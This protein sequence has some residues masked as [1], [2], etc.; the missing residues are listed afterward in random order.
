MMARTDQQCI[1][2]AH[3]QDCDLRMIDAAPRHHDG[4]SDRREQLVAGMEVSSHKA[5]IVLL[6]EFA[7]LPANAPVAI[8]ATSFTRS[9]KSCRRPMP[10]KRTA[11]GAAQASTDIINISVM[12]GVRITVVSEPPSAYW[13]K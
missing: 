6:E 8:A 13:W 2:L 4:C 12:T 3:V 11:L 1:P 5:P 7:S 9:D 10:A